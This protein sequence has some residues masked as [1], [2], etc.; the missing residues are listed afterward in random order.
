MKSNET[1]NDIN[2]IKNEIKILLIIVSILLLIILLGFY[3]E[4]LNALIIIFKTLF[5]TN[6]K[7][8]NIS[9]WLFVNVLTIIIVTIVTI[10]L[11]NKNNKHLEK[12]NKYK[13]II[14][15]LVNNQLNYKQEM[16]NLIEEINPTNLFDI[17]TNFNKDNIKEISNNINTYR[18]K[19]KQ[20]GYKL[21]YYEDN[22]LVGD[23]K[24]KTKFEKE[25]NK[26]KLDLDS[27]IELYYETINK[28]LEV[29]ESKE[30]NRLK[31]I[32][33]ISEEQELRIKRIQEKYKTTE[34]LNK[35]I[36]K[37]NT[38]VIKSLIDLINNNWINLIE[39]SN[40]TIKEREMYTNIKIEELNK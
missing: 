11:I 13:Y 40:K 24:S 12:Q 25:L 38:K 5:Y 29:Q 28:G 30:N 19:L 26:F 15:T 33:S 9:L 32:G 16:I 22:L 39:L 2:K 4:I 20:S 31:E 27:K 18:L 8:N 3:K 1:N 14:K 34:K 35:D 37:E 7:F 6:N 36:E 10:K 17:T 21:K 23:F